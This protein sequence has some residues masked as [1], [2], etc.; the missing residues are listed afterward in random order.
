MKPLVSVIIPVYNAAPYLQETLDSI[1]ASTYRPVEVVMVDDGSKDNSLSIAKSYCDQHPE[2][3]VIA[4]ENKGVSAAR[5]AAIRAAKGT[6]ILPVD[7][8]DKIADTFI[9]KAVKVI[10]NDNNIR[11]VG[12]RCWMFGAVD[13]EWNL[14]QFSHARLARKNRFLLQLSIEELIGNDVEDIVKKKSIVKIGT[15]G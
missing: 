1:L 12:C 11:V 14:P 13:K 8:D 15:S 7:A 5:N 9:E 6:Y 2:C 10:E 3:Q 4:Q